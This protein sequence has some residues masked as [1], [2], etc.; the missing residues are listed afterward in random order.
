MR[1][2]RVTIQ[3]DG[4]EYNGWQTQPL[5]VRGQKS[6]VRKI[7]TIQQTI[8]DVIKR[9]TG[10]EVNLIASGRTDAGVH[11]LAQVACFRTSSGLDISVLQRAMNALLPQ[12]IRITGTGQADEAFHPRY[13]AKRKSYVYLLSRNR[14]VS[15]FLYR[16]VWN[17]HAELDVKG[18]QDALPCLVGRHDFSSF[19]ASGCGAKSP[20]RTVHSLTM[21]TLEE[22]DLMGFR[23][24]GNFFRIRVEGDAF[25]RHMVRNIVGTLV[26][27]GRGRLN[28]ENLE[29]I[30]RSC[31]RSRAGVTA[32]AQG[33]FMERVE[34]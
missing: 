28:A 31:E 33:L 3:Y 20:V 30:L 22:M 25:L 27:L 19:R 26:D 29:E 2:I 24:P 17:V 13:D 34:Y 21:E 9:I 5:E 15:P 7:T 18:M 32:P 1:N 12:D 16:Y 23:I 8:Q 11:A 14:S 10:E 6:E 4:T